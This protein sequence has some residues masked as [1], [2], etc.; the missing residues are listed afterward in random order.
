M[1]LSPL[2]YIERG[3]VSIGSAL[4]FSGEF[5]FF[6]PSGACRGRG[7]AAAFFLSSPPWDWTLGG[8]EFLIRG[9]R[10]MG[11]VGDMTR[12]EGSSLDQT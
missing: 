10:P 7:P 1:A 8:D 9:A 6:L 5:A 2:L 11:S 4:V 12:R 3:N